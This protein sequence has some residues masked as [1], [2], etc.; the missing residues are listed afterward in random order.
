MVNQIL[1]NLAHMEK[2]IHVPK[3]QPD[4][5]ENLWSPTA[6]VSQP[7]DSKYAPPLLRIRWMILRRRTDSVEEGGITV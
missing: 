1:Y 5:D 6:L 2:K 3:H 4:T 7:S